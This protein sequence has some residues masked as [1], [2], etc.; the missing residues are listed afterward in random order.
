MTEPAE[1]PTDGITIRPMGGLGNQLFGYA[2]GK[3]TAARLGCPLYADIS[4]FANQPPGE[5]PRTFELGWL[6]EAGLVQET[7]P[8]PPRSRLLRAAQR[9]LP[10]LAPPGQFTERSFAYD[11]RI[12]S[13]GPGTTLNGYFQ[14][15]RYFDSIADELRAGIT[16]AAPRSPWFV[17]QHAD[18]AEQGPWTAIHVRRGD[19]TLAKNT[20]YHGLRGPDYYRTALATLRG[21]GVDGTIAVFSDDVDAARE[22]L[23]DAAGQAAFI[24]PPAGTDPMES[25]LLMSGA[26]AIITANSSFSWW[27][28]WLA[29]PATTTVVAPD[30]WFTGAGYDERD[31]CPPQW[32]RLPISRST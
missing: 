16:A 21:K 1:R 22:L 23:G 3:A 7:T 28:A 5:T 12:E 13:I 32:V 31:L 14:S 9:R 15:W 8:R 11:D 20:E 19:Y 24:E 18:L 30:P 4:A 27:G 17:S 10:L 6:V 2:C 29:D 26:Q 25:I